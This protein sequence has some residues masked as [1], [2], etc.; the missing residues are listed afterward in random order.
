VNECVVRNVEAARVRLETSAPST[1][2]VGG[3]NAGALGREHVLEAVVIRTGDEKYVGAAGSM[4]ASEHVRE[5]QLP[6]E[7]HVRV[8]VDIGDRGGNEHGFECHDA[9]VP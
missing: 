8:A 6:G 7:A 9:G 3:R 4:I 5:A 2:E 1:Y